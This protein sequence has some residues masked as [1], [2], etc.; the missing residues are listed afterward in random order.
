MNKNIGSNNPVGEKLSEF[1]LIVPRAHARMLLLLVVMFP[2]M[3]EGARAAAPPPGY[4]TATLPAGTNPAA[5]KI[6]DLDGDGLNDIAVVNQTGDLQLFFNYGAGSFERLSLNGLWASGAS[7][8]DL[9]I[10]DLNGDGRNDLAVA[11][12]TPNGAVSVL[13]NLGNRVFSAPVQYNLCGAS[14]GVAIGDL[15]GDGD[16]DLAD[17]SSC[18]SAGIL[19]NSGAGSF[20]FNGTYGGGVSSQ[21]IALADF[22]GDNFKDIVYLSAGAA[23]SRS[24]ALLFNNR[25]GTFGNLVTNYAG[26]FPSDLTVGDYNNDGGT[27]IAVANAYQSQIIMLFLAP[28]GT[29]IGYSELEGGDTPDSIVSSDLN[30]DGRTDLAVTSRN[31]NNL[32]VFLNRGNFNFDGPVAFSAGLAPVDVAAGKLDADELPDLVAVNQ[33]AGSISILF[34]S[35]VTPPVPP[36]PA[37]RITLSVSTSLTRTARVVDLR[38]DGATATSVE[39]YR[40]GTRLITVSNS[41]RYTSLFDRRARGTYR[42][43]VCQTGG[44]YCSNEETVSF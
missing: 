23:G 25:N 36:L 30:G 1:L 27:D 37:P 29:F 8:P 13:L 7:A 20:V 18:N 43:K 32:S 2:L 14:T 17:I 6:G 42:Y 10:G 12:P 24:V 34:S 11:F 35:G 41:G 38:W 3:T 19:L 9:E 15:D 44:Q 22:N 39:I 5:A 26:S 21:S 16:N 31:N 28:N 40:N 33:G 4:G